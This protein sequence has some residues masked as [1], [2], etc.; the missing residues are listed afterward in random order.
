MEPL[1]LVIASAAGLAFGY[2][3]AAHFGSRA[4]TL[5]NADKDKAQ[6]KSD[7]EISALKDEVGELKST[8]EE[9][10]KLESAT[11]N[12]ERD[13]QK[14]KK[15]HA[16]DL[17][18]VQT[19][20]A[21]AEAALPNTKKLDVALQDAGKNLN[22]ILKALLDCEGQTAALVADANGINVGSAGDSDTV[23]GGL[24]AASILTSIPKRL[25]DLLPL[26]TNFSFRLQDGKHSIVGRTF[27]SDG[28]LLALTTIGETAPS[29]EA[30]EATLRC[31][32]SALK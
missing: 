9:A 1:S 18:K 13:L 15:G 8:A 32:N 17:A 4:R 6:K 3:T 25:N 19:K 26:D 21:E 24:A 10:K 27:E 28:D 29:E 12:A 31:V 22:T 30:M 20:L 14:L 7:K 23:D 2:A 11:K 5:L 16:D